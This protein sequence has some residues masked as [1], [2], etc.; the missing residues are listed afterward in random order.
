MKY[1]WGLFMFA[2]LIW[3]GCGSVTG[4]IAA[5]AVRLQERADGLVY[6]EGHDA[7]YTGQLVMTAKGSKDQ[8]VS[9]Y[10]NGLRDGLFA[11][12]Y[13]DGK[14]KAN[15][16]FRMNKLVSGIT[17]KPDGSEGSRIENGNGTFLMYHSNG[18]V[19][20]ESVYLNGKRISRKD[21]PATGSCQ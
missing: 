17:W 1:T 5:P 20:R 19:A 8:W 6:Q 7:P 3:E 18:H 2:V 4:P 12:F 14:R 13:P 16:L 21:F 15:A 11:V 9:H 10:K